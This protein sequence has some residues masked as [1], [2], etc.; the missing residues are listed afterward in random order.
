MMHNGLKRKVIMNIMEEMKCM[1]NKIKNW[2]NT[3]EQNI[4]RRSTKESR[5]A[6]DHAFTEEELL[7][8]EGVESFPASDPPGHRSKS[9]IDRKTH[10]H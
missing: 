7:D 2:F 10:C 6:Q 1:G 8:Q 9:K 5:N 4:D 3:I